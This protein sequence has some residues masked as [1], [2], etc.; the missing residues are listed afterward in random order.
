M[1][2]SRPFGDYLDKKIQASSGKRLSYLR[3]R[4]RAMIEATSLGD[5]VGAT[6]RV[7]HYIDERLDVW[8]GELGGRVTPFS[9]FRGNFLEEVT[10][11]SY[12]HL[13]AHET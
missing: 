9:T 6:R 1:S 10:P 3:G 4:Y 11:V 13:R 7:V 12:T 5:F 8:P 2:T